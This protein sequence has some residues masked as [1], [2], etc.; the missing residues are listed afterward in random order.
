VGPGVDIIGFGPGREEVIHTVEERIS[1]DQ[2]VEALIANA[3]I[4]MAVS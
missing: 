4:A 2:M 3:A 1:I